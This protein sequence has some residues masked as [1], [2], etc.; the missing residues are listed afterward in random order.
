MATPDT[1][2]RAAGPSTPADLGLLHKLP[3]RWIGRG[4]NL[5]ARPARQGIP[6]NPPFFLQLNATHETLEFTSIGGDIPNRGDIEKTALLHAVHY[7]QTVS[8]CATNSG[9]HKE[10]GLWVHVPQTAENASETYVRQAAIPHG[11]S[12][13]AQSSFFTTVATGPTIK[14]VN[15]FPFP[16]ADP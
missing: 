1:V 3:G 12:L 16:I 7:L 15:S 9:I 6:A 8:D 13:L 5:I 4:F 14:S 10:P 2:F 11:D